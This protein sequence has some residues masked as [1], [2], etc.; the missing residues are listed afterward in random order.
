M[1]RSDNNFKAFSRQERKEILSELGQPAFRE[2]QIFEWICRGVLSFDEMTNLPKELRTEL[3]SSFGF[4]SATVKLVQVS[5]DGTRKYLF[6]VECR[7]GKDSFEKSSIEA[8]MIPEGDRK[9]LCVSSQA[10]CKMGCRFCMTGRQGFHG[11][12]DAAFAVPRCR[13]ERRAH[14][15]RLH[16]NGRTAGQ[17]R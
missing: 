17:L 7:I 13:G 12:L 9:T 11:N 5:E 8:V 6:P 14:Q 3:S 4:F 10:G 16:G 15:C 1:K 2:K